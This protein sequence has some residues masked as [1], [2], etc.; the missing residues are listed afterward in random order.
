[1]TWTWWVL[2]LVPVAWLVQNMLHEGS[3]LL[4]GWVQG[5]K[6]LGFW[7]YPHKHN[8]KFYFARC[9]M[10]PDPEPHLKAN[11]RHIAPFLTGAS[12]VVILA[13]L[14]FVV[15]RGARI[16]MLPF[17]ATNLVDAFWFWRGYLWSKNPW[18]D[19]Q[20]WKNG[21]PA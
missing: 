7:P 16:W 5:L 6:P 11:P 17:I 12:L 19:G 13:I 20:R 2:A 1:M 14:L 15:P 4:W 9:R 3:H 18:N 10:E 8:G 21:D